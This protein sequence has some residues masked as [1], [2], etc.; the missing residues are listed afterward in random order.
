M[1]VFLLRSDLSINRL[2]YVFGFRL[3]YNN[4]VSFLLISPQF[5]GSD[6]HVVLSYCI[7][8]QFSPSR[9]AFYSL[10][11]LWLRCYPLSNTDDNCEVLLAFLELAISYHCARK[12]T[13]YRYNKYKLYFLANITNSVLTFVFNLINTKEN[14]NKKPPF[15]ICTQFPGHID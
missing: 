5:S 11:F 3:S 12:N 13:M 6:Y 7:A 14:D 1:I 9:S 2:P 10:L 8:I 15:L 4:F